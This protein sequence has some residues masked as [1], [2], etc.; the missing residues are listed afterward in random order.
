MSKSEERCPRG[1]EL[2]AGRNGRRRSCHSYEYG[3]CAVFNGVDPAQ[4]CNRV[5]TSRARGSSRHS[6][7]PGASSVSL[8]GAA[9]SCNILFKKARC[10]RSIAV[11]AADTGRGP[12]R[13][14]STLGASTAAILSNPIKTQAIPIVA[15]AQGCGQRQLA[16]HVLMVPRVIN[17]R[18]G[19]VRA[20]SNT[21]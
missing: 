20:C 3:F 12:R 7:A 16:I 8:T 10:S 14:D 13:V 15:H 2:G 19:A 1:H 11:Q 18:A 21:R 9:G 5:Q 4:F 17:G 6:C